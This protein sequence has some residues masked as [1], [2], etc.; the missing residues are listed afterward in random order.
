VRLRVETS[1]GLTI[2]WRRAL[3]I[4]DNFACR[5][6]ANPVTIFM[7]RSDDSVVRNLFMRGLPNDLPAGILHK[8]RSPVD[9][10]AVPDL[11]GL[12]TLRREPE[13]CVAD[14]ALKAELRTLEARQGELE[15]A[16][17]DSAA[18]EPLIHP[19]LAE[20]YRQKVAVL[21]DALHDPQ[22]RD[23][24]FDTIRSLIEEI[25]LVPECGELRIEIKG[26]LGGILNLCEASD[27]KKPGREGRVV[28]AA[29]QIKMV[30]GTRYHREL[31][32]PPVEI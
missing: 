31:T 29:E 22:S 7:N 10:I 12:M 9:V 2:S 25:R 30:A 15:R 24:A 1:F 23:E 18:P 11:T 8:L 17:A 21:H 27:A 26:E 19:N 3:L 20:V 13:Q 6:T 32:L 16:L 5:G 14:K 4:V 28:A